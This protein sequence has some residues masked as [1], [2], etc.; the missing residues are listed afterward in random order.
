M[1]IKE[2]FK[3]D[4]LDEMQKQT[5]LK[6]ESC[7]F[8]AL[9]VL[10]L[11]ALIIESLLGFTPRE[12]AAEWFIFM[13]GCA[14]AVISDLRAGI[15][16]RRF[17]PNT[18]TNA[19][20]S[21]AGGVAVFV[22]GL[23][24]FAALGAGIAVLQAVIMGAVPGC[25]ALH[26]CSSSCRLTK[27]ATQNWKTPRRTMM[28]TNKRELTVFA[29]CAYAVPFLMMPLL[30]ICL[31]NGQDTS[32][33]ANAQMFYPAA[34][35]MLAFL[36]AR[37]PDTPKRFYILH[38]L[39]TA[40]M[41]IMS[42]L[43]AAA[44]QGEWLYIA[45]LVIVIASVLGWILL[46]TEKKT[47]REACGLRLHGKLLTALV[48]C[49]Y[50]LA[51]KTAM[52]FLSMAMQGGDSWAEY[53]AYW[54]TSAPW[55]M[56]VVLVPNFFLSFLPFFGE[57]YGWRYYLTPALQGRF[58]ARRGALAV[59]VL[60]GLWHLPLNLFFYSP[61][62]S[63]QSIAAQLVVCVTLGVFFTFAYEKCGKNIW[64]PVVLHYL[65]NNMV[66]VWTGTADISNQIISWTDVAIS[67][68]MY[69]V[70]FLPFLAA[71]CYRKNK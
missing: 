71:K 19:V 12:M 42:V 33:F 48:I 17:K 27:S 36:L 70:V 56:A 1:N 46:L 2:F 43:S 35:V 28:K 54:R 3:R 68:I 29:V 4:N 22:W 8:W 20:V 24:K 38:L 21:V 69:G 50:F 64:L 16:D 9:W 18:K 15:W 5:L 47:K 26:C 37:R 10:L 49:V 7:G 39:V 32:I 62:T 6:I 44:P 11:A 67:A 34:G 66:L 63:L 41:L 59:G 30:Y 61:D 57:E 40:I 31:Q 60:W 52:V 25:C 23:I 45:N 13:L 65:N 55:V 51:V 14:Y 58:G 53:L